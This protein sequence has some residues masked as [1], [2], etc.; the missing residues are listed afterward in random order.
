MITAVRNSQRKGATHG[1]FSLPVKAGIRSPYFGHTARLKTGRIKPL[2]LTEMKAILLSYSV[3]SFGDGL[4]GVA[5]YNGTSYVEA[6]YVPFDLPDSTD[7]A[8]LLTA[9]NA[10]IQTYATN[11]SYDLSG[12]IFGGFALVDGD[13]D[14]AKSITSSSIDGKSVGNTTVFTNNSGRDFIVTEYWIHPTAITGLGTAPVINVGKTSSSYND[15]DSGVSLAFATN[16][17]KF[18][19]RDSLTNSVKIANGETLTVRVATAAILTTTYTF[20]VLFRGIYL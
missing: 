20:E 14:L 17:G 16:Q 8:S 11:H 18:S 19:K 4:A 9:V 5:F 12:G 13:P 3:N 1:S 2:I 15:V 10:G 7:T 6:Q